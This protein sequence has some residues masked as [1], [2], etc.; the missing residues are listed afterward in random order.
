MRYNYIVLFAIV[1]LTSCTVN[2]QKNQERV[3]LAE[4]YYN[5]GKYDLSIAQSEKVPKNSIYF[6]DARKW[7]NKAHKDYEESRRLGYYDTSVGRPGVPRSTTAWE[8]DIP[9]QLINKSAEQAAPRNR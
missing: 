6:Q 4:G 8:L 9:K 1:G 3:R 5:L 7:N 2:E